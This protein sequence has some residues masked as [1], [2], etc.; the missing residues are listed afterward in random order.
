MTIQKAG[1]AGLSKMKTSKLYIDCTSF[2][3]IYR[4]CK[5]RVE[6]CCNDNIGWRPTHA[7]RPISMYPSGKRETGA[8]ALRRFKAQI[9]AKI[10]PLQ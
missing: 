1:A 4:I 10:I 6:H 9:G 8:A 5:G 7:Y 2:R 3:F